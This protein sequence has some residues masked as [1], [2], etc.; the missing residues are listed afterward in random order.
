M[1]KAQK[2]FGIRRWNLRFSEAGLV[3]FL[4]FFATVG[5]YTW[6]QSFA[7]PEELGLAT[8]SYVTAEEKAWF[9]SITGASAII[10][11]SGPIAVLIAW[12][13]WR[14]SAFAIWAKLLLTI[15]P[16]MIVM[17]FT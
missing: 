4:V 11:V 15:F 8:Q 7:A 14:R 13:I 10:L 3:I 6:L 16:V 12:W 1:S 2:I 17:A 5:S 9:S